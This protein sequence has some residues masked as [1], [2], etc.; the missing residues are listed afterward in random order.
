[1][2]IEKKE[3]ALALRDAERAAGRATVAAGYQDSSGYLILWGV[4]WALGNLASYFSLPWGG[5]VWPV[6]VVAGT[7]GSVALGVRS[8]R[9]ADRPVNGG[10]MALLIA[11]AFMS[12]SIGVSLIVG[13][14]AF[15][16]VEAIVCLAVGAVYIALGAATGLRIAA[17][18][19]LVIAATIG[20]WLFAREQF[21]LWMAL[22]GG[23]G[24]M[25]GGLW[26]RRA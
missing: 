8:Q 17:V 6:L 5:V 9:R 26:L 1:M 7:V 20:G 25:L 19:A 18:G 23:G 11:L 22:A 10:L 12:F 24:L 15:V 14:R 13:P 16:Q 21:H 2:A 3:A 4:V